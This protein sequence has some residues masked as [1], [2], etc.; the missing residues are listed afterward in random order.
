MGY[1]DLVDSLS[2]NMN[3]DDV[4]KDFYKYAKIFA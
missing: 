4:C 3:I 1:Q 2:T